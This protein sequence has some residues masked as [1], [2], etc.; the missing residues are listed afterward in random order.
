[1]HCDGRRCLGAMRIMTGVVPV[2]WD[3]EVP[4]PACRPRTLLLAPGEH[5][6]RDPPP[7]PSASSRAICCRAAPRSASVC[8]V[9]PWASSQR[10]PP[11]SHRSRVVFLCAA[12][13]PSLPPC[14][15]HLLSP[16]A[17]CRPA[18]GLAPAVLP[19]TGSD[20]KA[21][22][23][24]TQDPPLPLPLPLLS[25]NPAHPHLHRQPSALGDV[26]S[27]PRR[28]PAN[29][30]SSAR[31]LAQSHPRNAPPLPPHGSSG[32]LCLPGPRRPPC[33]KTEAARFPQHPHLRSSPTRQ[34]RPPPTHPCSPTPISISNGS[35][36]HRNSAPRRGRRRTHPRLL[37]PHPPS[38]HRPPPLVRSSCLISR[39]RSASFSRPRVRS[40]FP[41]PLRPTPKTL[42]SLSCGRL[43][44]HRTPTRTRTRTHL[45][46]DRL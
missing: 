8:V 29:P 27:P 45:P 30:T 26:D 6:Y 32:P 10:A 9:R 31:T 2:A 38:P 21:R 40:F 1:M 35:S 43:L 20:T 34:L 15:P 24:R 13:C 37:P 7:R 46:L 11:S 19:R 16:S 36:H 4:A 39:P 18:R 12:G 42:I 44:T 25:T 5:P 17:P 28:C 23:L 14:P 41:V 22:L 33:R 3:S